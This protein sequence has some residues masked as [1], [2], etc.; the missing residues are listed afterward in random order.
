MS[1]TATLA[2]VTALLQVTN[3]AMEAAIQREKIAQLLQ[4]A[5]AEKR[6]ISD[7]EWAALNADLEAAYTRAHAVA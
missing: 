5:Q 2:A 6:D 3:I 4:K 1:T 7:A